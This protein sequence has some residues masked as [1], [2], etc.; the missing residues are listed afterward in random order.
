[1]VAEMK[2]FQVL[3]RDADDWREVYADG[4]LIYE[5]HDNVEAPSLR[6]LE[7]LKRYGFEMDI[8]IVSLDLGNVDSN[9]IE[10][11]PLHCF[12]SENYW[13]DFDK[14]EPFVRV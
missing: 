7:E 6:I 3:I 13:S 5:G 12:T 8:R 11:T 14:A 1:M 2:K 4:K 9:D 10:K